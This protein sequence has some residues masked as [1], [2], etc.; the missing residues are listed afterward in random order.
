MLVTPGDVA[1]RLGQTLDEAGADRV[2]AAAMT[3]GIVTVAFCAALVSGARRSR[4]QRSETC[5]T[6]GRATDELRAGHQHE[7]REGARPQNPADGAGARGP[8]CRVAPGCPP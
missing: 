4:A 7:D 2:S 3:M 8:D 5:R 6:A 1:S